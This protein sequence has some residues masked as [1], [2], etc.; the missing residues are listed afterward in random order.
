MTSAELPGEIASP[1]EAGATGAR[2]GS[3]SGVG[4]A[5]TVRGE[6]WIGAT[7]GE[8]ACVGFVVPTGVESTVVG[9]EEGD[10]SGSGTVRNG[11]RGEANS[12]FGW[13]FNARGV[14]NSIFRSTGTGISV[15]A[16]TSVWRAIFGSTDSLAT[17]ARTGSI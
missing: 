10:S 14:E 9:S 5:A 15:L 3:S 8:G 16:V 11:E 1:V 13:E 12:N 4:T 17:Q 2:C 7:R 6:A